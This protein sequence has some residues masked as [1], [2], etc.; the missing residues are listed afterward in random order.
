M[1]RM[2]GGVF[3]QNGRLF[4][5]LHLLL[6]GE[7]WTVVRLAQ[8]ME[9]SERTIRRDIDALSAAGIPIYTT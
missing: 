8:T 5:L 2:N 1:Q 6:A 4:H 3:M 7:Q 9:V